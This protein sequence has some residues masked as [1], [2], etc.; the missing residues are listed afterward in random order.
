MADNTTF[1]ES[2]LRISCLSDHLRIMCCADREKQ[3]GVFVA[4]GTPNQLPLFI[5]NADRIVVVNGTVKINLLGRFM[6][7]RL[8]YTR[9]C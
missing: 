3:V 2:C 7:E 1:H 5:R 4:L 6:L 9:S 8:E